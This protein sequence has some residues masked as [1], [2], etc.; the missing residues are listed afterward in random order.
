MGEHQWIWEFGTKIGV[1]M[2]FE[3]NSLSRHINVSPFL[4]KTISGLG[5]WNQF[6]K[7]LTYPLPACK[8]RLN[9]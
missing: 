2:R 7:D 1:E 8:S 4:D 6:G 9:A 3:K 5:I